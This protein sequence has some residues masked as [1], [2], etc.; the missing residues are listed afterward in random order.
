M[1]KP[2]KK[3]KQSGSAQK[4]DLS[5]MDHADAAVIAEQIGHKVHDLLLDAKA[6]ANEMLEIYSLQLEIFEV[7]IGHKK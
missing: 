6:K 5:K 7:K 2:S 4:I 1:S 3:N